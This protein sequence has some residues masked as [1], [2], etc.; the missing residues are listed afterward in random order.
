MTSKAIVPVGAAE[1]ID[2]VKTLDN[3]ISYNNTIM[4]HMLINFNQSN[5]E[6][7][8]PRIIPL[9]KMILESIKCKADIDPA[10]KSKSLALEAEAALAIEIYKKQLREKGGTRYIEVETSTPVGK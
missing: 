1:R 4:E 10:M 2:P 5:G 9:Q 8:D 6:S 3:I 7:F